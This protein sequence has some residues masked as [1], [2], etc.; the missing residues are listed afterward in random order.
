MPWATLCLLQVEAR[1]P[2]QA[3]ASPI[4][5]HFPAIGLC[6]NGRVSVEHRPT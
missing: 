1:C 6:G 5:L 4:L 3:P 2:Q